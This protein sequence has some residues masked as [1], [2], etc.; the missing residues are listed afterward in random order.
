MNTNIKAKL[1]AVIETCDKL[2]PI[3]MLGDRLRAI[4]ADLDAEP[5]KPTGEPG[6]HGINIAKT[7][8]HDAGA[9][10]RCSYCGR[11]TDREDA[12]RGSNVPCDCRASGGWCGSF[13]KPTKDSAWC[14]T[15]SQPALMICK[16]A[17]GCDR[18]IC[19]HRKPHE[20]NPKCNESCAWTPGATCVPWVEPVKVE[21]RSCTDCG[22]GPIHD[23]TCL[24][25]YPHSIASSVRHNWTPK[26]PKAA[27]DDDL[28]D[29]GF[30]NRWSAWC[31]TCGQKSM[32]IV[33]PGKVQ[34]NSDECNQPEPAEQVTNWEYGKDGL[35]QQPEPASIRESRTE[36]KAEPGLVSYP[37][38]GGKG[39]ELWLVQRPAGAIALYKAVGRTDFAYIET[40][41]G[42]KF[43]SM[44]AFD[45][46]PIRAWFRETK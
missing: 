37:I 22:H 19:D 4:I 29:D 40:E 23:A 35:K 41:I 25:C 32:S 15:P 16:R 39:N 12:L 18:K 6:I 9:I 36:P 11:Y 21:H 26:E 3:G 31:P 33:R 20:F 10:A 8:E 17:V 45:D 1:Q 28:L 27:P 43:I 7:A 38:I 2:P 14:N 46:Q 42:D 13:V 5:P 34:C 30:G 24:A 44:Q